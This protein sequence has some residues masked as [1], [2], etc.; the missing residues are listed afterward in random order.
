[1]RGYIAVD[2]G[3]SS[4]R[5]ILGWI[6]AGKLQMKEMHRFK[7]AMSLVGDSFT[8]DVDGLFN[9]IV[10]GLRKVAESDMELESI[11][12][13][14]WGVDYVLVDEEGKRL[15]PVYAY[16]DHRTDSTMEKVFEQMDQAAI[17]SKTGIQFMQFNTIF[18]LYEHVKAKA[19][20]FENA[21]SLMLIPDYLHY[22]LSGVISNEYTNASTSQLLNVFD[23]DWDQDILDFLDTPKHLFSKP[24]E[25]GSVLGELKGNLAE[26]TGAGKIKVVAPATHDTGSAV[27][28]VPALDEDYVYI[29]SG[30]W[31][32]MGIESKKPLCDDQAAKYNF[33]NEGGVFGT[34]RVLKN[35]IGLWLIQEV[36]R[37]YEGKYSFAEFVELAQEAPAYGP[38]ID[39][40]DSRFI[41]PDNMVDAIKDY[42]QETG[43]V[44]PET[45]GQLARCI[46][47]SLACLYGKTLE[48][49]RDITDQP[50]S[51]IH[52][53]GG[54]C[55]NKMLNQL[56]ADYTGCKVK[57]GPVEATAIGNLLMQMVASGEVEGLKGARQLVL[58]SLEIETYEPSH[59]KQIK[60][61][62]QLFKNL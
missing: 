28:A 45:P 57:A 49:I 55:Q 34:Y 11:G 58:D 13:D 43:Q 40:S 12:V 59:N 10:S 46:F 42:C 36:S 6:E 60:K 51:R 5:V 47:E 19:E 41:N 25:A 39:P 21:F 1:M 17:Y 53:I 33:T 8:W 48:E 23:R 50:I 52:I 35:I 54:G 9:E 38:L 62:I 24:I 32:L 14:T 2:I 26:S 7:N 61:H 3:A 37:L 22:E 30:T 18:Q 16:R 20:D 29:S 56:C 44:I 15:A 31:S 4:G 27:V